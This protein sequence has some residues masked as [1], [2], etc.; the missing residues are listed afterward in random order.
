MVIGNSIFSFDIGHFRSFSIMYHYY[1][2]SYNI[3]PFVPILLVTIFIIKMSCESI[4]LF[5]FI[6]WFIGG[7]IIASE[8]KREDR[9]CF[10]TGESSFWNIVTNIR[11]R[12]ILY[13]LCF[14]WHQNCSLLPFFIYFFFVF[15]F[16]LLYPRTTM[17]TNIVTYGNDHAN[18]SFQSFSIVLFGF[19]FDS[20]L[21]VL[22][23]IWQCL[24]SFSSSSSSS[25]HGNWPASI[26]YYTIS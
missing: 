14:N 7:C 26:Y 1:I 11:H 23:E 15:R 13:F 18:D 20:H 10:W 25:T 19:L 22:Y 24:T 12:N 6:F 3:I 8:S 5:F 4:D 2:Y 16:S 21:F 9:N 17:A